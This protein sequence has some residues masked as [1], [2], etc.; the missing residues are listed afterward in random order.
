MNVLQIHTQ[1]PVALF[2]L[3]SNGLQ[4]VVTDSSFDPRI[5]D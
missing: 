4:Q 3:A 5:F 2:N 1:A